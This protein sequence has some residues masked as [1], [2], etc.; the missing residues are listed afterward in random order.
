MARKLI[1]GR[2]GGGGSA[3]V[4][5]ESPDSLQSTARTKIL[6]ALGNG[7]FAGNLSGKDIL[8]D[9]TAIL[10]ANGN[11]NFP[12]LK[13]EFRAGTQAQ[14][15]I[16][17][18]PSVENEVNI[19]V[20]LTK[21][22]PWIRAINNTQLSAV[23]LRFAWPA[24]QMQ[25]E[26][27][28]VN[29]ARVDYAVDV[30][31]DGGAY[32]EM[33]KTAVDGKSS[34]LYERSHRID[35][36]KA[37]TGWQIRARRITEDST[38]SRLTNKMNIQSITDVIDA[39]LRYPNTAL[40]FVEFDAK[41]FQNIP[42]ISCKP[43]GRI[44]RIPTTYNPE[45]RGYAG[46]WDGTFKWAYSN[47]PAWVFYDL[48]LN[49]LFGLGE[50]ID[51][52]QVD[53]WELY[54]IAQYCD[55]LVPDG[56]G[57]A[58]M[59]PRFLCDMYVQSREQ[60]FTVLRD[61]AAI[62]RGMTYWGNNQLSA[63]ADM[64]RDVDYIYNRSN[65]INGKFN[66]AGGS[67]KN[68]F[69]T[70]MVSWS[71][72]I[73]HYQD[74]I[75]AV[76]D[77]SLVRRYGIN[78][79]DLTAIGCTRQTEANRRGRWA[80]LS[81]SK[82]GLTNFSVGLDGMIPMPGYI[83]GIANEDVA[84]KVIGGRIKAVNGKNITLD[85]IA[86]AKQSDRLILNLPSGKAEARTVTA[87]NGNVVT[88]SVAYSEI[89]AVESAW[90]VDA[91]DLAIQQYRVTGIKYNDDNTFDVSAVEH[92]PD[93]YARIDNGARIDE[94]PISVIPPG[95]QQA[96][97]NVVIS[98]NSKVAQGLTVTTMRVSWRVAPN[99]IAYEAEWRRDNGNW[100]AVQRSSTAS[101]E[102]DGV[103]AGRYQARV[104][105]INPAGASSVWANAA[106]KVLS[107]KNGAPP[108]LA[109]F[110]ASAIVFGITLDWLFP[111]G[112]EDTQKVEV[113]SNSI[114][115][116]E[117]AVHYGD[118]AYPQ[119]SHTVPGLAAGRVIWF[120]ARIVDRLGNQ[121]PWTAWTQGSASSDANLIL[122]YLAGEIGETELAKALLEKIDN[123]ATLEQLEDA[124]KELEQ[125]EKLLGDRVDAA[126]Q[127]L[128]DA[129]KQ[130]EASDKAL[131][132]RVT[133]TDKK[134][135]A[136][137]ANSEAAALALGKR[138]DAANQALTDA[139]IQLDATDKKLAESVVQVETD[140]AN[141]RTE[142]IASVNL[143]HSN[144][145]SAAEAIIENAL[146][147]NTEKT[148]RKTCDA[149]I[150]RAQSLIVD[151]QQA[152][153]QD[154][155]Q[156]TADFNGQQAQITEVRQTVATEKAATAQSLQQLR[157]TVD[158]NKSDA[159]GKINHLQQTM[160]SV[161]EALAADISDVSASVAENAASILSE[162]T[163]R[164]DAD[165]ALG[166]RIDAVSADT[167]N[168]S[169]AIQTEITAR[170]DAD[171]ALGKRVD[172]LSAKTDTAAADITTLKKTL[173]DGDSALSTR[174]D[175][176][177]TTVGQTSAALTS[178]QT[179]RANADTALG[180]RI[181]SVSATTGQNTVAIQSETT[182]RADADTALGKRVDSLKTTTDGNVASIQ[183][184]TT[185]RTEADSAL[186][187]RVDSVFAAVTA[188]D[189]RLQGSI[190]TLTQ[191]VADN[192]SVQSSRI[193]QL[194]AS[195]DLSAE[196]MIENALNLAERDQTL[197]QSFA[198]VT[199]EQ[200][201]QADAQQAQASVLQTLQVKYDAA[202]GQIS[203]LKQTTASADE[204]L[205]LRI[206]TTTS[207]LATTV[208]AL[209]TE[210]TARANA[211]GA[212]SQRVDTL[213][214]KT[215]TAAAD[216]TTLKK[217]VA[218]GDSA[219]STRID[220]L[221]TTV[222]Q[223]SAALTSEQT[224]RANADTA[225]G[226]RIDSVSATT[227]QNTVAIQSETT[228]RADADTALG[229][230]V[231]SLKT[232]TDSNVVA[233]QSETTARTEA[234]SALGKR[235]DSISAAVTT[236]DT[237][238]QG[239]IDTLTQVVADNDSVQS[240]R[241]DQL[242][243]SVDL[244][245]EATIEN[246]LNLADRD[247]TTRKS[248]ASVTN[249]QKAQADAQQAQASVLQ[250]LQVKYDAASGQISDLKQTTASADEALSQRISTTTS[251]LATTVAALKTEETARVTADSALSQR[252]DTVSAKT[253]TAAAD[254]TTLKKTVADG[255][256]AL[257][258]RID[259][260]QTTVGQ[261]STAITSE[262][263][264]RA[265]GD[266]ALGQ[267][268]DSVT[269]SV[270]ENSAAVQQ[271]SKA[272]ATMEGKIS[273]SWNLKVNTTSGGN[274]YVAGLG[275]GIEPDGKSQFVV[276]ADRFSVINANNGQVSTPFTIDNGQVFI[277]SGF[278][279]DASIE[280]AKIRDGAITSAKIRDAEI[281]TLKLA[282]ASVTVPV[283]TT[284][285][286]IDGVKNFAVSCL[287]MTPWIGS[288]NI[289]VLIIYNAAKHYGKGTRGGIIRLYVNGSILT[290]NSQDESI[291]DASVTLSAIINISGSFNIKVEFTAF[292]TP[293]TLNFGT[294]S[295][296][297]MKR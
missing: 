111:Q 31:T 128:V 164:A 35:L 56:R 198:S 189:T 192:D 71:N 140:L 241:I 295:I 264:A 29:G 13:W 286:H 19:G 42:K 122:D 267:R 270:G 69:S 142:L 185:A 168:N 28:D 272:Q 227:G 143:A 112:A 90:S 6:I 39:K 40:L 154:V 179:A 275:L 182:A 9:G 14:E 159:E 7:E 5:V 25:E 170:T 100:I 226:Q 174:I 102:V 72:P 18:I 196:A 254:I 199:N 73:N 74:E 180:Q 51:S 281:T 261:T 215:D 70:A 266:T 17:G 296:I 246:A 291:A 190:D 165:G 147:L 167:S 211:D 216:I 57:G 162:K 85:R 77:N 146:G 191:V 38:T 171:S 194:S 277:K 219:L 177:Q 293:Y 297:G 68:R 176:L 130:L 163:A 238:L 104:R 87:I 153:A 152:I 271:V 75:E 265:N 206:S 137:I 121:G 109:S 148:E 234:D 151:G 1:G 41:Q 88:V 129:K 47:N 202:S 133:E 97:T 243:A 134:L 231:D 27:G 107:G 205:S 249:E 186:G 84:G 210:E 131:S 239:S 283:G 175:G 108:A 139:R 172:T 282:G 92:D 184:E 120:K 96:P 248:F 240:S 207:S 235:V 101:F 245:A 156:L 105:A 273:A 79:V 244:S 188:G 197:R 59:E 93:K 86:N 61:F 3:H 81:N 66:R 157:S 144:L 64:P 124:R 67:Q 125:A 91:N 103:Y 278:L 52:T 83:I 221:Q 274:K 63:L 187:K 288:E 294:L 289:P 48:V 204:A 149:E 257:A 12:G 95:A 161:D 208:A 53:K 220:G 2:K 127:A 212:L 46:I 32:Q 166:E 15:Y 232:T 99:A 94:R 252:I 22:R 65:V 115:S 169:A 123:S 183:S 247:K 98:S 263:T 155:L 126:N 8:L 181:D 24:I 200:K 150:I 230:R 106:E 116:D 280:S 55:Q 233:I 284:H 214:A 213:S 136:E 80:L 224:T 36:P 11:E 178:E 228:A 229:K 258:T 251:S 26:N 37:T 138:A 114:A 292:D 145:D 16:Q 260:L 242:S 255:D 34:S 4:P 262:Q 195:V 113:W 193:D 119:N 44:I 259:G 141:A 237:R 118:Y 110:T 225:L 23:R 58:G 160:A 253:D 76:S 269:A 62:F 203:D 50:K 20:E 256:G 10:D 223:T 236:G 54:R 173:A 33:L 201:T 45:T 285:G 287:E 250:T 21:E 276:Q 217:T 49:D 43:R 222:G 218:D 209:K 135:S 30:A 158:G 60:A 78:N 132:D 117:A 279:A 268:I 89:P 290:M 82:D